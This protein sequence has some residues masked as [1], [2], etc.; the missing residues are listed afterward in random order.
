MQKQT[1]DEAMSEILQ[2]EGSEFACLG[3]VTTP[4]VR[5]PARRTPSRSP[6]HELHDA[7]FF[8]SG[9]DA[10]PNFAALVD[11]EPAQPGPAQPGPLSS[12][13][14]SSHP[15][16]DLKT[17]AVMRTHEDTE[18]VR[19]DAL[20]KSE[21]ERARDDAQRIDTLRAS[22]LLVD[23]DHEHFAAAFDELAPD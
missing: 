12:T 20:Q 10:D 1:I 4:R 9:Y 18:A 15:L 6:L 5:A 16:Y 22:G 17:G 23:E 2:G 8:T 13:Q 3:A 14:G 19:K 21:R 7:G 11:V